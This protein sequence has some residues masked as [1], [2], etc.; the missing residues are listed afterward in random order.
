MNPKNVFYA[1]WATAMGIVVL[2]MVWDNFALKCIGA[3]VGIFSVLWCGFDTSAI[4]ASLRPGGT[5]PR[6]VV[7]LIAVG[8]WAVSCALLLWRIISGS[9]VPEE[10]CVCISAIGIMPYLIVEGVYGII[11]KKNQNEVEG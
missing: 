2:G 10:G 11:G 3:E 1:L 5:K 8:M 4:I 6:A 7:Y 9:G